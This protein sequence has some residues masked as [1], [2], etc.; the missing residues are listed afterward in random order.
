MEVVA[1]QSCLLRYLSSPQP[2]ELSIESLPLVKQGTEFQL[3]V[4]KEIAEIEHGSTLSYA[5]IAKRIGNPKAT[6]AV[7]SAC[8]KN[9]FPLIIPCHR[10][11][12]SASLGGFTGDIAIK[13][14]L[15]DLEKNGPAQELS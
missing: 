10:V 12:G 13:K 1:L 4:W 8:G 14:R 6:R 7:G 2:S 9:P 11:I 3:S 5:A 15:L